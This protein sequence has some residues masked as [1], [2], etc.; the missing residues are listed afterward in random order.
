MKIEVM[1]EYPQILQVTRPLDDYNIVQLQGQISTLT[2]KI[3]EM[4]IPRED[5]P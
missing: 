4:A 1:A 5:H 2:D 3:Q